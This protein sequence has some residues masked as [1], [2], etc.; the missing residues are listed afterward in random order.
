M[1]LYQCIAPSE[2]IGITN[3]REIAREFTRIHT[4][5]TAAPAS[6]VNVVFVD[7]EIDRTF[8]AGESVRRTVI[9]GF[10]RAGRDEQIRGRLLRGLSQ[11]WSQITGQEIDELLIGLIDVDPTSAME[12][13]LILPA[14]GKEAEWAAENA[15]VIAALKKKDTA[16]ITAAGG[17]GR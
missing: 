10:I 5:I 16:R 7:T 4:E 8:T 14:P 17:A 6:F 15:E 2:F 12:A 1:P 13:G 11:T 3:R 9:T